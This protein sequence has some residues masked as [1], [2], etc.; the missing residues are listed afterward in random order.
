MSLLATIVELESK[1][2]QLRQDVLEMCV[3]AG[4]GHVTSSFSCT[5][6]MT[7]LYYG[8]ILRYDVSKPDWDDR[9]RFILSKAQASPIL[10]CILA[11]LGFYPKA[12]TERFCC[13]DGIFGVHLQNDVPG[14][15][16]TGGS[17]IPRAARQDW[18]R[19]A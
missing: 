9:D 7:A 8:G 6:I 17:L 12:K 3:R 1:A 5:E 13:D 2:R 4:T 14:V 19:F 16:T 11:D 10:Y 15:E 18:N